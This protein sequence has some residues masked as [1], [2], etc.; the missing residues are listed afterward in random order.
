MQLKVTEPEVTEEEKAKSEA[1]DNT[2]NNNDYFNP[3][4]EFD[5]EGGLF[6]EPK[7]FDSMANNQP[8]QNNLDPYGGVSNTVDPYGS[9]VGTGAGTGVGVGAGSY[10]SG[11][12]V[13]TPGGMN[14]GT[15]AGNMNQNP[16]NLPGGGERPRKLSKKEFFNSPRNRRDRDRII[17]S[18]IVVI[19]TAIFDV[20]RTDF[21]LTTF[22][23]QI[24]MV[25]NLAEQFGMGAE[26]Q[27][28]TK[29][30]MTTQIFLSV[31][32]VCLGLGIFILKSRA[33]AITGL[34]ITAINL[35][36]TLMRFREFRMYWAMIAFVYAVVATISFANSWKE[37]EENGDWKREWSY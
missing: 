23:R 18:S 6:D 37:Y 16:D 14:G 12:G 11:A 22:Q 24:D 26:Y 32:L 25:N 36:M 19:V 29:A 3:E 33:C 7:T 10:Y 1:P 8:T 15:Q 2:V 35:I 27:I 30:I 21:W 5:Y 9:G 4:L 20:I 34:V 31:V 17:I 13:N 28:D